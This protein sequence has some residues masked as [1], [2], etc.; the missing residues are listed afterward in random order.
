[1]ISRFAKQCGGVTIRATELCL[2]FVLCASAVGCGVS[3]DDGYDP[4]LRYANRSD[5]IVISVPANQEVGMG[6]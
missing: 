1:M 6:Q 3:S 2:A 5:P 4:H